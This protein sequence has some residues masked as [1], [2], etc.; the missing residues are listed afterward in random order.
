MGDIEESDYVSWGTL[1]SR[2]MWHGGHWGVGLCGMGDTDE[3]DY[4]AWG[5]LMSWTMRMHGGH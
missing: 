3:L 2:T 1:R 4:E 5:T